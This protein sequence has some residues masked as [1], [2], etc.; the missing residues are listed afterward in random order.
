MHGNAKWQCEATLDK[1]KRNVALFFGKIV[2]KG[3]NSLRIVERHLALS[4]CHLALSY[5]HF[6]LSYCHFAFSSVRVNKTTE[7]RQCDTTLDNT[8]NILKKMSCYI[9]DLYT[10]THVTTIRSNAGYR[11]ECNFSWI[12]KLCTYLFLR[13]VLRIK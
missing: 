12:V 7:T 4:P 10:A 11:E 5:C 2:W 9:S 3:R 13:L 1:L 8:N 6:T